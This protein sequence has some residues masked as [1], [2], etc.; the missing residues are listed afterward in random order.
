MASAGFEP[1]NLGDKG[2]HATLRPPKPLISTVFNKKCVGV[3][4]K[5]HKHVRLSYIKMCSKYFIAFVDSN[6]ILILLYHLEGNR[7]LAVS[8]KLSI[9]NKVVGV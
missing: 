2:Q 3:L 6:Y 4:N 1:A 9:R 8:T 5:E 7:R